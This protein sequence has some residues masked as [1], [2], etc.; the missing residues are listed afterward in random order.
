MVDRSS[1]TRKNQSRR[2][3]LQAGTVGIANLVGVGIAPFVDP[4]TNPGNG[5]EVAETHPAETEGDTVLL[6]CPLMSSDMI[7]KQEEE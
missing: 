7:H 2:G 6:S 3:V 5:E 4:E 1:E